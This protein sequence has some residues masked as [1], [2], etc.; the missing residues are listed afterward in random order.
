MAWKNPFTY[1]KQEKAMSDAY[2]RK[3][4]K[5]RHLLAPHQQK[6]YDMY[7][8]NTESALYCSRKTGKSFTTLLIAAEV[9]LQ[10]P[11]MIVRYAMLTLKL[12]KEILLPIWEE[13]RNIIPSDLYPK[14][15]VSDMTISFKNGSQ[16]KICGSNRES[17]E[18]SRGPRANLV[19]CDEITAWDSFAEYMITSILMPQGT[20]VPNFKVIYAGTPPYNMDN[21]FIQKIYP[22]LLSNNLLVSIDIDD[23]PFLTEKMIENIIAMYP[24]GREDSNFKR[25]HKLALIP[26]NNLR[27]VPEFNESHIYDYREK[28]VTFGDQRVEQQYQY[29][30]SCDTATVDNTAILV[31][32]FD[33]NSQQLVIEEE[34]V[35]NNINLTEIANEIHRLKDEYLSYCYEYDRGLKIIIDAFS[36]ERK[37]LRE[38]HSIQHMNPLK[39]KVEDNVAHLR[40]GFENNKILISE[41]CKRLIWELNHCVWSQNVSETKQIERNSE[42]KH[43]DAIMSLTYMFRAVNWRFRPGKK[44]YNISLTNYNPSRNKLEDLRKRTSPIWAN[45]RTY[46]G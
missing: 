5:V 31:G 10:Q 46:N 26:Q 15:T 9:C 4:G 13:L 27:V 34:F 21:Y 36:L 3:T 1:T 24:K 44:D 30:I 6:F 45:L 39:G 28:I 14:I 20:L 43:G 29:F 18:T 23:N 32:Y 22:R 33:H 11:N 38:I 41:K 35:K 25:E 19:I 17:A 16:I 7:R 2:I 42:Q 8:D 37:E 40:S 12:A